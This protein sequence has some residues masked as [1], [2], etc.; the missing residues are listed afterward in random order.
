M[1]NILSIML[2]IAVSLAA[3]A[4]TASHAKKHLHKE[5]WYQDIWCTERNGKIEYRLLDRTRVDC[6]TKTHAVEHDFA[7]NWPE[8]IGQALHYG[9]MTG[10]R[11]GIGLIIETQKEEK[12]YKQLMDNI[13]FYN[14]PIDVWKVR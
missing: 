11:A 1:K 10:K 2:L 8:A 6:L 4:P 7:R 13:K 14:L 5:R 3:S 9:R 12:Y